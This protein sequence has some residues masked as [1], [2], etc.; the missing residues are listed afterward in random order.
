MSAVRDHIEHLKSE[1]VDNEYIIKLMIYAKSRLSRNCIPKPREDELDAKIQQIIES[2]EH[3]YKSNIDKHKRNYSEKYVEE[4]IDFFDRYPDKDEYV[5]CL[6][7]LMME[8]YE[9]HGNVYS[10]CNSYLCKATRECMS[11]ERQSNLSYAE[12]FVNQVESFIKSHPEHLEILYNS[13]GSC[14]GH[15]YPAFKNS[16]EVVEYVKYGYL[17]PFECVLNHDGT[18]KHIEYMEIDS[19]PPRKY[20]THEKL[21]IDWFSE[22][23]LNPKDIIQMR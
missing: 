10:R 6:R 11:I 8:E 4:E 20:T 7:E 19:R 21:L 22:Y 16:K 5:E 15:D 1:N 17:P 18:I 14:W 3:I 2:M 9:K 12:S 23:E 13:R